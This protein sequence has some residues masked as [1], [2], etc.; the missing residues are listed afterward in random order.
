MKYLKNFQE[1]SEYQQYITGEPFLPNV[2]YVENDNQVYYN[3]DPFNGHEYV[4][5]GLP[6]GTKWAT[7]NVGAT[8]ETDYGLYFQWGD[9]QGYS[10]VLTKTFSWSDYKWTND[11]GT[12]MSKYNTTDGKTGLDIEDDAVAVAWGG[13]WKMPTDTQLQELIDNTEKRWT[14][15]TVGNT[16]VNGYEFAKSGD[17]NFSS[18][19]LFIPAAGSAFNGGVNDG[20]YF[21]GS[22]WSSSLGSSKVEYGRYFYFRS[23]DI[24]VGNYHRYGGRTVRG[25]VSQ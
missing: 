2:S 4:D 24:G 3:P 23:S 21:G 1:N 25:V 14:S 12:T 10:N 13:S 16:T 15:R 22:V 18:D 17:T 7:M 8:S 9:T 6:S 5:L 19:T 20:G 11:S